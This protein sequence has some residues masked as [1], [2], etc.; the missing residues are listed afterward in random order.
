MAAAVSGDESTR[1]AHHAAEARAR[2]AAVPAPPP[3]PSVPVHQDELRVAHG[4]VPG[5]AAAVNSGV[6]ASGG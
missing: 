2:E 3:Q 4:C 1:L 5:P 6:T